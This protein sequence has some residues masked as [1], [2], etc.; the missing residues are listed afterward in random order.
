MRPEETTFESLAEAR[1]LLQSLVLLSAVAGSR[2]SRLRGVV[3][4]LIACGF[5]PEDLAV[6]LS[7]DPETLESL[8]D[9]RPLWE[10]LGISEESL[11][12]LLDR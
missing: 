10:R 12:R 11:A 6:Q 2:A 5:T 8:S 3:R 1:E 9:D 7:V 4:W